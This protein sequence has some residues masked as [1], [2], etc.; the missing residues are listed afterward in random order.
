MSSF[1]VLL[2]GQ[3]N[4]HAHTRTDAAKTIPTSLALMAAGNTRPKLI[5]YSYIEQTILT[6]M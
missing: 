2:R 6:M 3:T 4:T 1:S 5:A